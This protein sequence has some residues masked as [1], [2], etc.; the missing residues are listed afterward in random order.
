MFIAPSSVFWL[1]V[2]DWADVSVKKMCVQYKYNYH[3]DSITRLQ[4][5]ASVE[6]SIAHRTLERMIITMHLFDV[7]LQR[8]FRLEQQI[9]FGTR[10]RIVRVV[11]FP[12]V[13]QVRV[14]S[15]RFVCKVSPQNKW[16]PN[17]YGIDFRPNR[18][19]HTCRTHNCAH[20]CGSSCARADHIWAWISCRT[21]N[22]ATAARSCAGTHG[23]RIGFASWILYGK[24]NI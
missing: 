4:F 21:V 10:Q 7:A 13:D 20:R 17:T 3:C 19:Y 12:M 11:R 2:R 1:S 23:R 22:T 18:T 24:S 15:K 16:T 6:R 5:V 9:A 8:D 14:H